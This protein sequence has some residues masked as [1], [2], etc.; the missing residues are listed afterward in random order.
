MREAQDIG[1]VAAFA[2]ERIQG[3]VLPFVEPFSRV[4]AVSLFCATLFALL[5]YRAQLTPSDRI[6]V[7]D[8]RRFLFPASVYRHASALLDLKLF[9]AN[10]LLKPVKLLT[11]GLSAAGAAV[12]V[13][14]LLTALAGR[15]PV[16]LAATPWATASV[17]ILLFLAFDFATYATHRLSHQIPALWAFHRVH[18]SA[19]VLTPLTLLRKHPIYDVFAVLMDVALVGPIQGVLL[20]LLGSDASVAGLA[21][22]NAG[23]GAFAWLAGAL[24]HSHVWL[25]F[26]PIGDRL[27][28]SPAMHQIHH[29][30]DPRHFD[31][32][33]GEVLAV[34]DI[35]FRTVFVPKERESLTFGLGEPQP[36]GTLL[37]AYLEPF[38]FAARRFARRGAE[39]TA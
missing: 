3:L 33:F 34:W 24:R 26:G 22:M 23:F 15:S 21:A 2:V 35:L 16:G 9:A 1:A 37:N 32:N 20:Y 4:G 5:A 12:G 13:A 7:S 38:A 28:I 27:V 14:A 36:H 29:S 10:A 25:S 6:S 39:R 17:G 19:E 30:T 11:V 18:H 8:F 31:R